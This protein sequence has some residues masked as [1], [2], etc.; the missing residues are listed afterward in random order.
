MHGK[1]QPGAYR[2]NAGERRPGSG[3]FELKKGIYRVLLVTFSG[4]SEGASA[5]LC[6]YS[7]K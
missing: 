4:L 1:L 5:T 2:L 3:N 7:A 6:H